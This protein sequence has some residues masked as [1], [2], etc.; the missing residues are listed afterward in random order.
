[1]RFIQFTQPSGRAAAPPAQFGGRLGVTGIEQE[2]DWLFGAALNGSV[3]GQLPVDI[4]EDKDN[5]YVRAEIPGVT[6]DSIS[7]EFADGTLSIQGSRKEKS[8]EGEKPV[9]LSRQVNIFDE[10]DSDKVAAAYENGVL[11]VTLPRK[12]EAKPKK[13]NVSV[14]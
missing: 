1:M 9:S 13:V 5:T 14:N 3:R 2:L 8:G 12:E 6:R 7:V 10:V 11:T 4:Y